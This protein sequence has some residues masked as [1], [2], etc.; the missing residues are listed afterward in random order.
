MLF[1]VR[2]RPRIAILEQCELLAT[3]SRRLLE[4]GYRVEAAQVMVQHAGV[5]GLGKDNRS[6][7]HHRDL[8]QVRNNLSVLY[9]CVWC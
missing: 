6:E 3:S 7:Y 8:L 9:L 2:D 5:L 4:L 1:T